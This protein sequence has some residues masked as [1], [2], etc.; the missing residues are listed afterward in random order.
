MNYRDFK[1]SFRSVMKLTAVV[2]R[3]TENQ[4]TPN[5]IFKGSK[6]NRVHRE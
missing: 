3:T 5:N 4:T 1:G 6:S 2:M